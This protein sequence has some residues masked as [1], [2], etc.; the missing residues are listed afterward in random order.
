MI[1]MQLGLTGTPYLRSFSASVK[2]QNQNCSMRLLL[3]LRQ[4]TACTK[5]IGRAATLLWDHTRKQHDEQAHVLAVPPKA[6]DVLACGEIG[7]DDD[8]VSNLARY[9]IT[10]ADPFDVGV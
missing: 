6:N 10:R 9:P 4:S 2:R 8:V 3:Y 5:A 1:W 7:R